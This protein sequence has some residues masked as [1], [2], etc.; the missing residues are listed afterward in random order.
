MTLSEM[1]IVAR[2]TQ[3]VEKTIECGQ[4]YVP[5]NPRDVERFISLVR[6]MDAAL[7][8]HD[9]STKYVGS[10]ARMITTLV[11]MIVAGDPWERAVAAWEWERPEDSPLS[12]R[13][14][15]SSLQRLV[16]LRKAVKEYVDFVVDRNSTG[17]RALGRAERFE[18]MRN[19]LKRCGR[20]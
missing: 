7:A 9:R 2:L 10:T 14:D 13:P 20:R 18:R 5:S 12:T 4:M 16:E 11:G 8:K 19:A 15:L 1:N 3:L 17:K 6:K